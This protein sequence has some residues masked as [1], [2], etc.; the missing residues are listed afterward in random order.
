MTSGGMSEAGWEALATDALGELG[1]EPVEGKLI[2]PGS[3]ERESWDQLIIPG[4]LQSA[5]ERINPQLPQE[6]VDEVIALVLT[7]AS[8]DVLAE[9]RRLHEYLTKG[10]R[11]VVYTDVY[12]ADQ[13]PTIR[14]IDARDPYNNDFLAANQVTVIEGDHR[15][16]LDIVAY[17]N[18]L[19]L[20][21]I[22]LKKAGDENEDLLGAHAQL[23]TYVEELPTAFR[24]NAV[25]AVTDGITARYGTAF[26]PF[27]H[28]APW[29]VDDEGTPVP[30]PAATDADLA[31]NLLLYGVFQPARLI[32]LVT[33]YIAFARSPERG[34]S[35]RIAKAQQYF[36]VSKA[37]GK[38]IEAA[39]S[40]GLAGVVWHT[41]GSGK[42]MEM[43]L[44]ANQAMTHPALGNPTLLVLTDRTDLDDQLYDTFELSELLPESPHQVS[45]RDELR[46]ELSNRQTGGILFSTLQKFSK[47]KA[48]RDA[49]RPHPLLSKRRNI[50]VIVDE[51]HRSH[52]DSLDG[53]ARHL[54]DA[55]PHATMIA[56]TGT[57]I[58]T[59]E[60]NTRLVFGDYIDIYDLTRAVD[61]GATV[62]VFYEPRLIPVDLPTGVDPDL[63]DERADELTAGLDDS[64]RERIQQAVTVMNELYGAPD[65]LRVLAA[66]LV[67]HWEARSAEMRKF[68]GGPGKGIIVCATREICANLYD[69]ITSLRPGWASPD[70]DKGVIKVVYTGG[71]SDPPLIRRHVR[72]PSQNKAIQH[73]AKN[74]DDELQLVIVQSMWLTG[75]DS[76]PLHTLYLDRPMRGAALMQALARVNRTYRDKQDGL[77]VGYAPLT[78]NLYSALAEYTATDQETRPLGRD[79]DEA[80]AKMRDLHDTI[81]NVILAE[82]DWRGQL[83][84]RSPRAYVNAVLG[85]VNYLRD[86][87]NPLNQPPEGEPA[88]AE[89]FRAAS[90]RLARF[91]ALCASSGEANG[92]RDDIAFFEEVRVWMAKFDAEDRKAR[93]LPV[94]ADVA[95]YLRQLTAGAV[96]AGGIT[97]IYS[98]AGIE[99]PDLSHLDQAFIERMQ[100][101]KNP[102]LAIEAL[103]R[104]VEQEMRRVTRHN[105][106]RQRSF[107]DRLLELMRKYT[108]QQLTAAE[109]IAELVA[110]AIEV[111]ADANR[112]S[113]FSPPLGSDELAFYDAVAQ[114][115]SAVA[116]MGSGVLADIARDL[117]KALRR[118]VTTDWVSRDDV[119]AKLRSTIKRLLAKY[120][121]PPDAQPTAIDLVIRQMETFADE[122][123]PLSV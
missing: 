112:G 73:R 18:G 34:L 46:T 90:A 96:E 71:P 47:T 32:E 66:D 58:S 65:R 110:M 14:L 108:N 99:R 59:A 7:P 118:D 63:I 15:R 8:R 11:S 39:R 45:T 79:I 92:Y 106:V 103:R 36:A 115:E 67:E 42:S 5:I 78:E 41:Q 82:C 17:V 2:A 50:I 57:P 84:A 64:E 55:L 98:A 68:I 85:T 16:R 30:Q 117:V 75:F 80:L 20:G 101:A 25:A 113:N 4:R 81:G 44:Y 94:P 54:R 27:E 119:R 9:N 109:I 88:L 33:G 52:Y 53:Y 13:N 12:G 107:S 23:M 97:D 49:G 29:L 1:W 100:Q 95:L 31:I 28:F 93:G 86:V 26:T 70:I 74:S 111:S 77:L 56:F 116:E 114:N 69:E 40:H 38:T 19:P 123:S 89:R 43:E 21:V 72:R 91:Y 87:T 24:C 48:E 35:K 61:D 105:L 37:I 6:A 60:R 83:A 10:I 120:G 121:Y 51:A 104:L 22:E 122:W 76:P 102:Q 3:G 62:P